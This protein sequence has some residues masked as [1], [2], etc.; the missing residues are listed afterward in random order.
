MPTNWTDKVRNAITN[1]KTKT[2]WVVEPD[3]A[4]A[5][6]DDIVEA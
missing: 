1:L 6:I 2:D 3:Q 5:I 4:L